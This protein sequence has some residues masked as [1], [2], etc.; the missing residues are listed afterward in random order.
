[1]QSR[2]IYSC[3]DIR[4][5]LGVSQFELK[6]E[7]I[8]LPVYQTQVDD[9]VENLHPELA[10]TYDTIVKKIEDNKQD[11]TQPVPTRLEKKIVGST[12]IYATYKLAMIL[13]DTLAMFGLQKT[14]DGKAE[15]QR[16]DYAQEQTYKNLSTRTDSVEEELLKNLED[17]GL[18][19]VSQEFVYM[20]GSA[21]LAVDPI[22]G[23]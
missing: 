6:D 2:F 3:N 19:V 12:Q 23:A 14:A 21:G 1:M 5:L 4:A 22:T 18:Q 13:A 15:G 10:D 16:V 17:F 7:K 11:P 20:I 8:L 9:V